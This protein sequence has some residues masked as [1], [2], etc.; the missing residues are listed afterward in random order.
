MAPVGQWL[1]IGTGIGAA[2][3][4]ATGFPGWIGIGAGMG[5]ALGAAIARRDQ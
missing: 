5:V 3:F 1:A 2:I 4:A